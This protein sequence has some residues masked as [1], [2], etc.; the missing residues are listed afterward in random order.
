M[1]VIR[2]RPI[3]PFL[4]LTASMRGLS[5]LDLLPVKASI[6]KFTIFVYAIFVWYSAAS[7]SALS[8]CYTLVPYSG[9]LRLVLA[10]TGYSYS[11]LCMCLERKDSTL[12]IKS[13]I[14]FSLVSAC[15]SPSTSTYSYSLLCFFNPSTICSEC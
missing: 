15:P 4:P 5:I 9:I 1:I 14:F 11:E 12:L 6:C 10:F 3:L 13:I 8:L 2:N 7:E